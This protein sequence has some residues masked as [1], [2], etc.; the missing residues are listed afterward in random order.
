MWR[1]LTILFFIFLLC[2]QSVISQD[3]LK[4]MHY[5][6]LWFGKYTSYCDQLNNDYEDKTAALKNILQY[7]QPD[8]LTVNELDGEGEYP[9]EDGATG[10]GLYLLNNALNVD[11][12]TRYRMAPFDEVYT[13]NTL[14]YNANKL[15]LH[16]HHPVAFR[17]SHSKIF[18]GYTFYYNADDLAPSQD[19]TFFTVFVVHLKAGSDIENQQERENETQVL[20]DYLEQNFT[21]N[22]NYILA[23]DL[24]V[25]DGSEDAFQKLIN[26]DNELYRFYDP[27]DQVGDWH[28]NEEYRYHHTQSTHSS[29]D[30]HSGG[31]MDDRFDFILLSDAIMSGSQSM[32]YILDSYQA[33]GQDGSYFNRSLNIENNASVSAEIAGALYDFSDHLPVSLQLRVNS[34]PARILAWD[35]IYH[36]PEQPVEGDSVSIF[37]QLTDTEREVSRLR[38]HWGEQSSQY[39]GDTTMALE[40]NYYQTKLPP[41]DGNTTVYYR[42]KGYDSSQAVVLS[43]E[44]YSYLVDEVDVAV[45]PGLSDKKML[46][47]VHPVTGHL[48]VLSNENLQGAFIV[49]IGDMTGRTLIRKQLHLQGNREFSVDVQALDPGI[50]W[51]RIRNESFRE[52]LKFIKQ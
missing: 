42:V 27:I 9:I 5:N 48:R 31:G 25:Y 14:F 41:R 52:V 43:S 24:N 17:I 26:P 44:E 49:E 22:G 37:A 33:I 45:S 12:T 50:Y 20:M 11:G 40:G 39:S 46:D 36:S 8:V 10:D 29:T 21:G 15:T 23:G 4:F 7:T 38:V 19:T 35:T 32:S 28:A 16:A 30:C 51:I 47:V 13:A 6:L 18:N 2:S 3:N 34:D 1:N